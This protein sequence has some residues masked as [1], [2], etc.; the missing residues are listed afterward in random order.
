MRWVLAA[1]ALVVFTAG[2]SSSHGTASPATTRT[3]VS[4]PSA[5]TTVPTTSTTVWA[6]TAAQPS[7]DAAAARLVSAWSTSNRS[8]ALAVAAPQAVAALFAQPYPAGYLQARGCTSGANPAT[9]T[10]RNTQTNAI[11]E[12]G[13]TSGVGGWYVSSVTAET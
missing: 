3:N 12:I 11:F 1:S 10:Y 7:P 6:P 5:S 2:C 8:A 4:N 9:C 13:I